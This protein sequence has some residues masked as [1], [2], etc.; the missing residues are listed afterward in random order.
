MCHNELRQK[1]LV[2]SQPD[3]AV[4]TFRSVQWDACWEWVP[5]AGTRRKCPTG[6]WPA[7]SRLAFRLAPR[8]RLFALGANTVYLLATDA[9]WF[10]ALE[11]TTK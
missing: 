2:E 10:Q 7:G 1:P 6:R 11:H 8:T 3:S 4:A 9:D 5:D